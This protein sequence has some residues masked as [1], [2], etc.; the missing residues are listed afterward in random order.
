MSKK[1][2]GFIGMIINDPSVRSSRL[3][4]ASPPSFSRTSHC[5]PVTFAP[6]LPSTCVPRP[7]LTTPSFSPP[8]S[9]LFTERP[10][11]TYP[12]V[13]AN[14][15]GAG[16]V[17]FFGGRKLLQHPDILVDR[18]DR[19]GGVVSPNQAENA[20]KFRETT[21]I[22]TTILNPLA[23]TWRAMTSGSVPHDKL[24]DVSRY[25]KKVPLPTEYSDA[26]EDGL[27]KGVAP[28]DPFTKKE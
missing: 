17:L 26:F 25:S 3:R 10:T 12:L 5:S 20:V 22:F 28:Q 9:P 27:Y 7:T 4:P 2:G 11:Q 19:V 8:G 13:L 21:S 6:P 14:A 16:L 15:A 1:R 24:W 23:N 18:Q